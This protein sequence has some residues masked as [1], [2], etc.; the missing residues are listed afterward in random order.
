MRPWSGSNTKLFA[1]KGLSLCEISGKDWDL[2]EAGPNQPQQEDDTECGVFVCINADCIADD[3]MMSPHLYTS[4]ADVYGHD[5]RTKLGC[6]IMRAK[7]SDYDKV[8]E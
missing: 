4:G 6:D 1:K 5:L 2:I 7:F 3:L 8:F